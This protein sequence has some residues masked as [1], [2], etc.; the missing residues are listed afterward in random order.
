MPPDFDFS[1]TLDD[2]ADVP[3]EFQ[4]LYAKG[5]DG[6]FALN[7]ALAKKLDVSPLSGALDKERKA[8]KDLEKHLTSWKGIG[9]LLGSDDPEAVRKL[10]EEEDGEESDDDDAD[11]GKKAKGKL[12]KRTMQ[13]LKADAEAAVAKVK[14][15][16]EGKLNSLQSVL[17]KQMIDGEAKAAIAEMKGVPDLL[18][19]HVREKCLLMEEDGVYV[20]RVVDAEGDP[21]G[22]G[23]GGWLTIKDLV[24][25]MRQ[26]EVYGRAFEGEGRSG[27]GKQPNA[28]NRDGGQ[29][30]TSMQ[31]ISKGLSR[32]GK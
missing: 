31:K 15:E 3:K 19:P 25:E 20:V 28:G 1:P 17:K 8:R 7:A 26:S 5:G 30:L 6:K 32:L 14:G 21:R 12:D 9:A 16:Y 13:K 10:L 4:P 23:K 22:N 11:P 2:I 18:L 29:K 24:A 27:S